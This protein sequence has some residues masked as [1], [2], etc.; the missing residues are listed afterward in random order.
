MIRSDKIAIKDIVVFLGHEIIQIYGNYK[1]CWI[2]NV[3]SLD[4]VN[5][6]TLDWINVI[7]TDKQAIADNSSAQ[8][9]LVD[10]EVVYS[11]ILQ[12]KQK[13]LIVVDNPRKT[14]AKIANYFFVHQKRGDIHPSA[15]I[16]KMAIID[17]SA[18][19]E[20]GCV[21]G[22]ATIGKNSIIRANAVIGDG[23]IIGEDCLIQSGSVIGTDGLGC[24]REANGSLVKFPHLGGVIIGNMVEIGSNCQIARGALSDTVISDGCKINGLCFIAHNCF[25]GRNVWIT[26]SSMLAGSTHVEENVTIYSKVIIR[27]QCHIEKNAVIGMGAVITQKRIPA[28]EIWVGNPAKKHRDNE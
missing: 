16:D 10:K 15:I 27:E 12:K 26:G 3:A 14:F 24:Q 8:C 23:T 20:A 25:L 21:I 7:R 1:D 9:I 22:K 4:K 11:E 2:D 5:K 17:K 13:V 6:H 28:G 18:S 19:I